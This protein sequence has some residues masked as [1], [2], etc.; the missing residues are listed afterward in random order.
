LLVP[1][2]V[3]AVAATCLLASAC[4][5]AVNAPTVNNPFGMPT[6]VR[7]PM[8]ASVV[9][10][11]GANVIAPGGGNVIA[12]G[13]G[14]Y[15][16]LEVPPPDALAKG[17]RD[18]TKVYTDQTELID[19]ILK[20]LAQLRLPPGKSFTFN[21]P[22]R[23]NQ[24]LTVLLEVKA[25]HALISIGTGDTAKGP[26]QVMG[27]RYTNPRQGRAV[28]HVDNA[29]E[30]KIYLATDFDLDAN[31]ASADGAL[32]RTHAAQAE[33]QIVRGH[34]EFKRNATAGADAPAFEMAGSVAIHKPSKADEDG[35][36]AFAANF[37]PDA[38][39]SFLFGAQNKAT[40]DGFVFL[41]RDGVSFF[42]KPPA[43]HDFYMTAKGE[44]MPKDKA[45]AALKAITP[46]DTAIYKPF[47][48]NPG[49]QDPFKDGRFDFPE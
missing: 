20:G 29:K 21:D 39:G 23:D 37:L 13:G 17:V 14:N 46:A 15:R 9:A 16:A 38:T 33:D 40:G 19:G 30:G 24:K 43:E 31:K 3:P 42:A 47:P 49:T 28:F 34:W 11:G 5:P 1:R 36:F 32:Y 22:K 45:S 41:P 27:L 7:L 26:N 2:L 12:P 6:T 48:E 25:D 35:V 8:P 18:N 44:D 4:A 10:S